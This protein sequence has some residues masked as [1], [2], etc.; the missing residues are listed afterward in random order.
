MLDHRVLLP[1][2]ESLSLQFLNWKLELGA[3]S[4]RSNN[5][6]SNKLNPRNVNHQSYIMSPTEKTPQTEEIIDNPDAAVTE[7]DQNDSNAGLT[8]PIAR[9][10]RIIKLDPEHVSS[11]EAANYMLGLAT[12]L[13]V[14]TLTEKA[15]LVTKSNKRKK[16]MYDDFHNVVVHD[17]K[18]LFLKDLIP[19]KKK[20]GEL[21]E[22]GT[23]NLTD[24]DI[25]R[26]NLKYSRPKRPTTASAATASKDVAPGGGDTTA[27]EGDITGDKSTSKAD[28]TQ[29]EA[30]Y[31][32]NCY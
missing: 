31:K 2:L 9:I 24:N 22:K 20:I 18:L 27:E 15:S 28:D 30:C 13:F 26:F 17:D 7:E 23:I 12:E 21:A 14:T 25:K 32:T 6:A 10:K 29:E 1:W 5:T 8:L 3:I 19:K 16:I 11:T 4:T